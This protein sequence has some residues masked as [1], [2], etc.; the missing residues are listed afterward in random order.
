MQ[1]SACE[2]LELIQNILDISRLEAGRSPLQLAAVSLDD[3]IAQIARETQPLWERP[4]IEFGYRI[5]ARLP[6][7][8][9]DP[10]K[11]KIVLK[12]LIANA[13]KF[14]DRGRVSVDAEPD[15]GGVAI[16]VTDTGV[17]I[18]PED[19]GKIFEQFRQGKHGE[20]RV[21]GLGLGLY[22]ARQLVELLGGT[23]SVDSE[24]GRGS[25]FRV[26]IPN[27][28]DARGREEYTLSPPAA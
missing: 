9:T 26:W 24:E 22:I 21:D 13:I 25:S 16:T 15:Q 18:A 14:T 19:L 20:R 3:L 2:L 4:G 5:D 11:L 17:G 12:N 23:I 27:R 8:H 6:I 28:A 1:R 7:Q 10:I